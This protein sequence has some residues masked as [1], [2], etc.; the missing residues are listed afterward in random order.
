MGSGAWTIFKGCWQKTF[1]KDRNSGMVYARVLL[2]N[3][4][5]ADN[6]F[7]MGLSDSTDCNCSEGRETVDH[8]LLDCS[9]ESEAR[10]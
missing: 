3:T 10:G 6:M 7:R 2:N 9:L 1:P 8:I 5:V 4:A